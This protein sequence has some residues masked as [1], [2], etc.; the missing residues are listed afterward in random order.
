MGGLIGQNPTMQ[1]ECIQC[2][3]TFEAV[4][5][6]RGRLPR[7]CSAACRSAAGRAYRAKHV[8][9]RQAGNTKVIRP[10]PTVQSTCE[11]CGTVHEARA[12]QPQRFCSNRCHD[13]WHLA[14]AA[15]R[16][17][18][19]LQQCQ[20]PT[21]G[22]TFQQAIPRQ[23]YCSN[24]CRRKLDW[25]EKTHRRR[26]IVAVGEAVSPLVVFDRDGWTCKICSRPTP[27]H[28]RG[29]TDPRAPELDH[30]IP[31][32]KGGEHTYSNTQCSCRACNLIKGSRVDAA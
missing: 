11:Q 20:C 31:L 7:F 21:C 17:R 30:V 2:G 6:G 14:Q 16:V 5:A 26:A 28:L 19:R 29:S 10:R 24:E 3:S 22:V 15:A 4:Y 25:S 8:E 12:G 1:I 32:S 23:R 27:K 9:R 18:A 13:D